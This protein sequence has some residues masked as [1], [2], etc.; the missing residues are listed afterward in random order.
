MHGLAVRFGPLWALDG[1]N[2][3]V[4]AGQ[5]VALA[6]ENGAGKTTLVGCVAGDVTPTQGEIL[7]DGRTMPSRPR[8][9]YRRGIAVVRQHTELCDNLDVAANLFLGREGHG[10]FFDHTSL[11]Q[12]AIALLRRLRIPLSDTTTTVGYLS[13]G[14][15]QLLSVARAM[16]DR[17]RLLILD[18]PTFSLGVSEGAQV[19]GLISTLREQGTTVL[20][21]SHDVDQMFRMAD[22]IV[23][24]RHGR[25]IADLDPR[26]SH[27]DDVVALLSGQQADSS[28]RRQLRRLQGL[29]DQLAY[30]DPSSSLSVILSSLGAALNN[31]CLS[32]HLREGELLRC[33]ASLGLPPLLPPAWVEVPYGS[34]KGPVGQASVTEQVVVDDDVERSPRWA[35]LRSLA[36]SAKVESCWAVPVMGSSGLIGV[37]TILRPTKGAPQRDELDLV[38]LYAGYAASAIERDRLLNDVTA[39][40]RVLE[41]IREV[42][43]TLA[44]PVPMSDGLAVAL[45]ALRRGLQADQ[46]TLLTRKL[47][48]TAEDRC[49]MDGGLEGFTADGGDERTEGRSPSMLGVVDQALASGPWDGKAKQVQPPGEGSCVV[50][51]F[52]T[53]GGAAALVASWRA[54]FVPE[55][56][57]ALI[58]DAAHSLQ[59]ALEREEVNIAHQETAAL[60]RSQE[61]QQGFLSRLSHE[62]RTP[63]TAI[64]GYASSL[65]QPDVTWDV[66]SQQRFLSRVAAES[67][68]LG[69]LV[70]DLLDFSAIE[71]GILRLH[72]DWCDLAIV[73]DAAVACL[74]PSSRARV[75]LEYEPGLPAVWA[76]H[77]RMEQVVLNLIDN[78]LRHNPEG[79]RVRVS[80]VADGANVAISISDDGSGVPEDVAAAFFDPERRRRTE[81]AGA[82]L[83]LSIARGIVEAHGGSIGL[84]RVAERGARVAVN[85]PIEGPG[86]TT[87]EAFGAA[88]NA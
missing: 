66:A 21:V 58:E 17:P 81:T 31:K 12:E 54:Q 51:T 10:L 73:L 6:G 55:G 43:E 42:L 24:L 41:T 33:A 64:R 87:T 57:S 59:L 32:I 22:R 34:A 39:R 20:L 4:P 62:L 18:E 8:A 85:I 71:S 49:F 74:P 80:T 82:G 23:V 63:L 56:S 48:A 28:A 60:R 38:R 84:A 5:L 30:T 19:E 26:V 7:L 61:M 70:E 45:K 83:G 47:G 68:R 3:E 11:H 67:A 78:A 75:S 53:V 36:R 9:A 65:L 77:D 35:Q 50:V 88:A 72:S 15:R 14:M 13:G 25:V 52:P 69:R 40:N 16:L 2:L 37:I 29:V 44:G 86:R 76:D 27:R 79:T 46:V 1:V